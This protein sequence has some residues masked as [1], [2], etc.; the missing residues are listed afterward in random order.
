MYC[1]SWFP[2]FPTRMYPLRTI[3]DIRKR[4][5]RYFSIS[6]IAISAPSGRFDSMPIN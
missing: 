6:F 2:N 4:Y 5:M 1:S 3:C